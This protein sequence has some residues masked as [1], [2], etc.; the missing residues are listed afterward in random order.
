MSPEFAR[1]HRLDQI[2]AAETAIDIAATAEERAAL[3]RRF[4]LVAI[5]ALTALFALRR[6]AAGV[7][8]RGHLSAAVTQSCGVTGDP[9]PATI[10]E[11]F[12]IRFLPEPGEDE[13]HD[14][15]ELAEEDLDTVFYTG[16]ALDLGEAAAET[17]ALALDP[18]PRSPGAAA[19]LREAGVISEDDAAAAPLSPLAAAL[20]A[21][22]GK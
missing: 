14:E 11:D 12:A 20:K 4:D 22:L 15:V 19:A 7:Q 21:K 18:F 1:P 3:A 9:L 17:L 6:D 8:A 10:E 5:D 16:S 2:G 13:S